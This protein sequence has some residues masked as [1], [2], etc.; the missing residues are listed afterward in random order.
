MSR[1]TLI[2]IGPRILNVAAIRYIELD[3]NKIA[4][5][6]ITEMERPLQFIEDE[7]QAL[8]AVLETGY[9]NK[10][11]LQQRGC[12]TAFEELQKLAESPN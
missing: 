5:V 11:E 7:C 8:M 3:G 10:I 4:N 6:Y 1:P 2:Q 12:N 9:L